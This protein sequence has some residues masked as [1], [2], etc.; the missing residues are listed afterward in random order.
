MISNFGSCVKHLENHGFEVVIDPRYRLLNRDELIEQLEGAYAH[1]ASAETVNED[2]LNHVPT[3]KVVSRMGIGY[4]KIDV[5][6]LNRKGVA[7]TITP[8]ANSDAV[9]EFAV[10]MMMAITRKVKQIDAATR[11]GEW[12]IHFGSSAEGKTLGVVG[13]GNIGKKVV[14]YLSGFEMNVVAYDLHPDREFADSNNITFMTL[15]DVIKQS[16]YLFLHAPYTKD[17]YRMFSTEQ[18][19]MMKKGSYFINCARGEIVDEDALYK[20]LKNGHLAGAALDVFETEPVNM[21]NSLLTLDN[22]IVSSHTSGMTFE[23]RKK[24]VD[25]AFQNIIDISNGI[26]PKGLVNTQVMKE[27]R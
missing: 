12:K 6:A 23:G 25:M 15:E 16:D 21:D 14:K 7:L 24:V 3:L 1:V 13:L 26:A 11:A 27:V 19:G 17:N 10:S 5:D 18:F 9:A 20:V 22:V 4:D 8:G 2:V